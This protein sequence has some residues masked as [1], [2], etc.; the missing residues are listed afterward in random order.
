MLQLMIGLVPDNGV[1]PFFAEGGNGLKQWSQLNKLSPRPLIA[2]LLEKNRPERPTAVEALHD[3]WLNV[4]T[5]GHA[6]AFD[7]FE[8]DDVTRERNILRILAVS[9][10]LSGWPKV[11]YLLVFCIGSFCVYCKPCSSSA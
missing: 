3:D 1:L 7:H 5:G 2:S 8:E 9:V 6:Y 11:S 4:D 10:D